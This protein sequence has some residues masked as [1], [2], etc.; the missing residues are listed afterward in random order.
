M[1]VLTNLQVNIP[2]KMQNEG[3][4][5]TVYPGDYIIGDLNGVVCLPAELAEQA[6]ALIA[7]QV[8]AD[9]WI[10]K[11]IQGGM[12]FAEASKKHRAGLK[13]A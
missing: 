5:A 3:Q 4:D 11:D 7:P 2:V 6:I 10:A 8:E 13:R 12:L 9:K 1:F